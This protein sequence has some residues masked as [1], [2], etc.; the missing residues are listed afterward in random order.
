[1]RWV[2]FVLYGTMTVVLV[3]NLVSLAAGRSRPAKRFQGLL[4]I[5]VPARNEATNLG[6]LLPSLLAQTDI[7]FEVIVYDDASDD[8]TAAV[9]SR[10]GDPRVRLLRGEGPPPGWVGKVHAL[11]RASR[12]ARGDAFLFLDA[13]TA[14][15]HPG[16]LARLAARFAALPAPGVFTALPRFRGGA[17][18]LVSVVPY[19][20]LTN[21]PLFVAARWGG[22]FVAA[23]NGQCWLIGRQEYLAH[24]P[25]LAHPREVLED[26]RIGQFLAGRGLRPRFADV[27]DDLEVWMYRDTAEAWQGFRKNAYLLLG[28]RIL[29]FTVVF[30][31]FAL[32]YLLAPLWSPLWLGWAVG[33]K[34]LADRYCRFPLWVTL[35]APVTFVLWA[36]LLMDS[37]WSHVRG[38][39]RWKGRE[40][41]RL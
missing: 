4:S 25:H 38:R 24:E 16:A 29:P 12:E 41:A 37:A 9:V 2:F 6:R 18:L 32:T 22:R 19:A 7:D 35:A 33:T 13:D 36:G 8:D 11:Y 28:G 5:L 3:S 14:L 21:L 34:L 30:S 40:V 15:K 10:V 39:V 20:F 17:P 27:Q 1:V 23:M 31:L 26:V